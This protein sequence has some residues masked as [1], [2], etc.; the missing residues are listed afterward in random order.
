MENMNQS[1][2][3]QKALHISPSRVTYG[4]FGR[5]LT[6]LQRHTVLYFENSRVKYLHLNYIVYAN[7]GKY[8]FAEADFHKQTHL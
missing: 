2:N 8:M 6:A 7:W 4:G 5:K 1:L 3:L